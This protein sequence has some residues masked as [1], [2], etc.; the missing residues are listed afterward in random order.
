MAHRLHINKSK[1]KIHG[2]IFA[3]CLAAHFNVEIHH[4]DYP[5][6]KVYLDHA[7]MDHH[8]FTDN[9]S[10]DIP[11]PYNLLFSVSTRD[12]IRLPAPTLFDPVARGGYRIMHADIIAYRKDQ[13]AAEEEPQQWDAWMPAP[14]LFD[15]VARGGYRIMPADIIAYRN[16]QAATVEEPQQWDEWMPAP[17]YPD[18][19]PDY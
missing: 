10:P 18:Y 9:N 14:S 6:T 11:I 5:L 8:H 12:I 13:A 15:H 19:Y 17:Q 16:N 1:G 3:T 7:A 2:G 4:H